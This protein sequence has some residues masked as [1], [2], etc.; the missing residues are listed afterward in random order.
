MLNQVASTAAEHTPIRHLS[1]RTVAIPSCW[2]P[3]S[4]LLVSLNSS[5]LGLRMG[6][7][8]AAESWQKI[9]ANN[10]GRGLLRY[11][12][13]LYA[14][15]YLVCHSKRVGFQPKDSH[16]RFVHQSICREQAGAAPIIR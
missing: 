13:V 8:S 14:P 7:F 5:A 11:Y 1:K 6:F 3:L 9:V 12:S 10:G 2:M 15:L 4:S 16:W